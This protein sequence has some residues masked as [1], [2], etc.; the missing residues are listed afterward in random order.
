MVRGMSVAITGDPRPA[1]GS[2]LW[3]AVELTE[4]LQAVSRDVSIVGL[5]DAHVF[6]RHARVGGRRWR[7][8]RDERFVLG[9]QEVLARLCGR[10]VYRTAAV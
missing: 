5:P 7:N 3:Q 10:Q 6:G 4:E 8:R 1:L 9:R 2:A